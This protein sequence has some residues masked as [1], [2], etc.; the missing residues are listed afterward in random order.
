MS[1][2]SELFA[3]L[4]PQ[5]RRTEFAQKRKATG[6]LVRSFEHH[7]RFWWR[8]II[9]P[10]QRAISRSSGTAR[11]GSLSLM[12]TTR[13]QDTR[14]RNRRDRGARGAGME[15]FGADDPRI[16]QLLDPL[17]HEAEVPHICWRCVSSGTPLTMRCV[18]CAWSVRTSVAWMSVWHGSRRL[19]GVRS[20]GGS[21]ACCEVAAPTRPKGS[22]TLSP[23]APDTSRRAAG[24]YPSA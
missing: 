5:R 17:A 1:N 24:C 10:R 20:T 3:A 7:L 11:C 21:Q 4:E 9:L 14:S 22:G 2:C 19:P 8:T 12:V 23:K 13:A 15:K 16:M 18:S 6:H